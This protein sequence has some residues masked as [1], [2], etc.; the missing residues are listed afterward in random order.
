MVTERGLKQKNKAD[1]SQG[2]DIT[3]AMHSYVNPIARRQIGSV[4]TQ[5]KDHLLIS[6]D[7]YILHDLESHLFIYDHA[8]I[9]SV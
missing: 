2:A 1:S 9:P 3:P 4:T 8:S 5:Q 7:L 6:V